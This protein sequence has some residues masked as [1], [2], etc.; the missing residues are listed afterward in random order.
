MGEEEGHDISQ[1]KVLLFLYIYVEGQND[2]SN[3]I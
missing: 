3:S 2:C 1:S